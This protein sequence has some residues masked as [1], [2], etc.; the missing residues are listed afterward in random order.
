MYKVNYTLSG[1]SLRVKSFETLHEATVFA[2]QQSL[3][4]VLEIKYY[5]DVNHKKPDRN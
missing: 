3:E 4:S 2:N 5:D 1:G